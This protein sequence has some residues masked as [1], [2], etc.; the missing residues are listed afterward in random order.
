MPGFKFQASISSGE[1]TSSDII[2]TGPGAITG[3]KVV[4]DGNN[5]ATLIVYDNTAASGTVID[6]TTV[7]A[8]NNYGG[9]N[10]I[11]PIK[12]NNGIYAAISGANASY[13]IEYIPYV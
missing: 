11:F 8:A 10:V 7:V 2:L 6:E 5:D 13:F 9:R 4:T 12:V 1:M 3:I